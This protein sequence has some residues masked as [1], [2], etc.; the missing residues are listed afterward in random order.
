V[1]QVPPEFRVGNAKANCPPQIS[2]YRY[3]NERSVAFKI[4]QNLFSAGALPGP[5]WGSSRRFHRPLSR[6]RREH[7]SPYST[8][9]GTDLHSALAMRPPSRSPTR[10]TPMTVG[11]IDIKRVILKATDLV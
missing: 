5:R 10:S 3:K 1:G 4:R 7:P 9:L 2:S 8:I 11:Y 6:L